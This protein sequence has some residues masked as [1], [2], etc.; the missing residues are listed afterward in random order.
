MATDPCTARKLSG[1][2]YTL[3]RVIKRSQN[4]KVHNIDNKAM[5]GH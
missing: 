3:G 2:Q 1:Q 5:T 4:Y